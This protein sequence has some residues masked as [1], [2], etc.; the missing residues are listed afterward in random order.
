MSTYLNC[1]VRIKWLLKLI[2]E[3]LILNDKLNI[4]NIA[5]CNNLCKYNES[6]CWLIV[7]ILFLL[8]THEN[9]YLIEI[10]LLLELLIIKVYL[11]AKWNLIWNKLCRCSLITLIICE[12]AII[13]ISTNKY[14]CT[15]LQIL[16]NF[17]ASIKICKNLFVI[18]CLAL[19]INL[20]LYTNILTNHTVA[21]TVIRESI[22]PR[23]F[24]SIS[25]FAL[26]LS[27]LREINILLLH[28]L[29]IDI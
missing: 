29:K 4:L 9:N 17:L 26:L 25:L 2:S 18:N 15:V 20:L 10:I 12:T 21:F 24:Y 28:S 19:R 16:L 1:I 22:S 5:V 14:A 13:K 7:I 6:T 23:Y 3:S 11:W 27:S 8:D